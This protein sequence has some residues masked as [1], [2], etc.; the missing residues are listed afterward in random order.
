MNL[1]TL[2]LSA[3]PDPLAARALRHELNCVLL[4][5]LRK[6]CGV[7]T[8]SLP[9]VSQTAL[10]MLDHIRPE[11]R[12]A[13]F[14][15]AIHQDLRAAL[16]SQDR[17]AVLIQLDYL[18]LAVQANEQHSENLQIRPFDDI[19]PVDQVMAQT[20]VESDEAGQ[21]LERPPRAL[22]PAIV[23]PAISDT[24][25]ALACLADA[26]PELF[27]ETSELVSDIVLADDGPQGMTTLRCFGQIQ[28][29]RPPDQGSSEAV[30]YL[31]ENIAHETSHLALFAMMNVDPMLH[32]AHVGTYTSPLRSDPRPLYG[33]F[34]ATFVLARL[35]RLYGLLAR[36]GSAGAPA[37]RD[38][39][40]R[41]FRDGYQTLIRH[42]DFTDAGRRVLEQC[43]ELAD[44]A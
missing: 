43:A 7:A 14:L 29:R 42:A 38:E 12:L 16:V 6:F 24:R 30:T 15:Y 28:I 35:T 8:K 2:E 33:I 39:Q 4:Q 27:G 37:Q 44:S 26:D 11:L 19:L 40:R 10:F 22:D 31:T 3:K 17:K 1:S 34:H 9:S 21:L 5:D 13:P 20:I 41:R 36:Q 18:V 23:G 25:A 32:N